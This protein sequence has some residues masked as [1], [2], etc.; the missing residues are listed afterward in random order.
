M[1]TLTAVLLMLALSACA[2]VYPGQSRQGMGQG[3][4][5]VL[6][7]H[8]GKNTLE[9]PTSAAQAH[10]NHGDRYGRC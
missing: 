6:I 4:D 5:K 3:S 1:K 2:T 10:I 9:L 7:C 8:K